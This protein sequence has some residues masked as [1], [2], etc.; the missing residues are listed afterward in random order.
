MN[1]H[2]FRRLAW[3]E[4][5][6]LRPIWLSMLAITVFIQVLLLWSYSFMSALPPETSGVVAKLF[7][8]AIVMTAMYALGCTA[9]LFAAEREE[10]THEFLCLHAPSSRWLIAG[11][12]AIGLASIA[13]LLVL[14]WLAAVLFAG[15]RFPQGDT[16]LNLWGT[17]GFATL[18]VFA[19]GTL[20][21]LLLKQ[22]LRAAI[23]AV[24][25]AST[26]VHVLSRSVAQRSV[27]WDFEPYVDVLPARLG[28]LAI[29]VVVDIWLAGRWLDRPLL[30]NRLSLWRRDNTRRLNARTTTRARRAMLP[31]RAVSLR[32]LL[33]QQW[34]H[35]IGMS[36]TIG[37]GALL[38]LFVFAMNKPN[39]W[40]FVMLLSM[41]V[42]ALVGVCTF[43]ADKQGQSYRFFAEHA[44]SP[45]LVWLSRQCV[46]LATVSV[47]LA[48]LLGAPL[49]MHALGL[50][51]AYDPKGLWN[52]TWVLGYW[53]GAVV[54]MYP[55]G[56]LCS[57][58]LRGGLLAGFVGLLL[59]GLLAWW[60]IGMYV[61]QASWLWSVA[62]ILI[63]LLLATWLRTPDWLLDRKG[64]R[65]WLPVALTLGLPTLALLIGVPLDRV[66]QIPLQDPGF[67]ISEF[68]PPITADQKATADM[69]RR[70][71]QLITPIEE[72]AETD[73]ET[74]KLWEPPLQLTTREI[75]WVE[76]NQ[77][78]VDLALEAS[79]RDDCVFH[80]PGK[81]S[82]FAFYETSRGI[83]RLLVT[84]ARKL[85]SQGDLE[86]AFES[87]R[88][89]LRFAG[90]LRRR[91]RM[92]YW[93]DANS[94]E[95]RVYKYLPSWAAATGQT[96]ERV[97]SA[98][99]EL[100][101]LAKNARPATEF[102]KAEHVHLWR[103][104]TA[105]SNSLSDFNLGEQAL[106]SMILFRHWAPW[107]LARARRLLNVLTA[108]DLD[109]VSF[110]QK[111]LRN[112]VPI[113]VTDSD[114]AFDN[115]LPWVRSTWALGNVFYYYADPIWAILRMQ[116]DAVQRNAA[117]VSMALSA[118]RIE[119]GTLPQTLEQL[120]GT[121]FDRLPLDPYT[122]EA[123]GY[124]R[125]GFPTPI[126]F[127]QPYAQ[128]IPANWPLIWSAGQNQCQVV[129]TG[130]N[131]EGLDVY[132]V[133]G[134]NNGTI[135]PPAPGY[136]Y[137][138]AFPLPE[139]VE[140]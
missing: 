39:D 100:E 79:T 24:L 85:Q 96:P 20:F 104:L 119:H 132:Q 92:H 53:F 93:A 62:P 35:T 40:P 116:E 125:E 113:S 117:I 108:E 45:G 22:P 30:R 4:Y 137:G 126:R 42:A 58:F 130:T 76:Q 77:Q 90:H 46:G 47:L 135:Q 31:S 94:V 9:A 80:N 6:V 23:L 69:Y 109:R 14:L 82:L 51:S 78:S 134:I 102:V 2:L 44:V 138:K 7:S 63:A 13:G 83:E 99:A 61:I 95:S 5:R 72:A 112:D 110:A 124:R 16:H 28:V 103:I 140:P 127:G 57:M 25:A 87:Y 34:R 59:A 139:F 71:Y 128:A 81:G 98:I 11:K 55:A 32:R 41:A 10:N 107:E 101:H 18:E 129:L 1:A 70:A 37:A 3:K 121:Y 84:N 54:L 89:T 66:Y 38:L 105:D 65:S 26:T 114:S 21:S 48:T 118:W 56:Q 123:F 68:A 91:A 67:S 86:G 43:L 17:F 88:A 27:Y 50:V 19:W 12:A 133:Q 111:E 29:V 64:W 120:V 136:S 75:R 60:T 74:P 97:R 36:A 49:A 131:E 52:D 106:R 115:N 33:W 8:V 73:E 122:G 15:G